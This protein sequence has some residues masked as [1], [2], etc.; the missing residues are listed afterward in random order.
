MT[1]EIKRMVF[2]NPMQRDL[3]FTLGI[4]ESFFDTKGEKDVYTQICEAWKTLNDKAVAEG[5]PSLNV[6]ISKA[7]YA[8]SM[9]GSILLK[10][11]RTNIEETILIEGGIDYM[12]YM[13]YPDESK[14]VSYIAARCTELKEYLKLNTELVLQFKYEDTYLYGV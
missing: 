6:N 10:D 12:I 13:Y 3:C 1:I 9:Q 14:L 5:N 2:E 8:Y 4:L 7:K 11:E